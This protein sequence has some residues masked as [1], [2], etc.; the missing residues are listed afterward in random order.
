TVLQSAVIA[1][2]PGSVNPVLV[3]Q[4][5]TSV[6][7]TSARVSPSDDAPLA[8][9][10]SGSQTLGIRLRESIYLTLKTFWQQILGML[11]FLVVESL[12]VGLP[13]VSV[14]T[15]MQNG[16]SPRASM[17]VLAFLGL[18]I[19]MPLTLWVVTPAVLRCRGERENPTKRWVFADTRKYWHFVG[20]LLPVCLATSLVCLITFSINSV[21]GGIVLLAIGAFLQYMPVAVSYASVD[22]G[23]IRQAFWGCVQVPIR[24]PSMTLA[25]YGISVILSVLLGA[26]WAPLTI[27]VVP[28]HFAALALVY[29]DGMGIARA[30]FQHHDIAMGFVERSYM[31]STHGNED[32]PVDAVPNA[33]YASGDKE[34]SSVL[35]DDATVSL[36]PAMA[37]NNQFTLDAGSSEDE[38]L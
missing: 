11:L 20:L 37:D 24:E 5:E 21:F 3:A 34:E 38:G 36:P 25:V 1:L 29:A 18:I 4:E 8:V 10:P 32:V 26:I 15:S 9:H 2:T 7:G 14:T 17:V 19:S 30:S 16:S 33:T 27:L 35:G 31:A 28:W 13:M 22:Q 6:V 12:L 23:I